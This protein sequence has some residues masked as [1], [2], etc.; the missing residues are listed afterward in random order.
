MRANAA[1]EP[2]RAGEDD[3][4]RNQE[5]RDTHVIQARD[6]AGRVI[7]VHRAQHLVA[8]QRGFDRDFRGF[9]ITDFADHDDVRVLAQ[10]R[11]KRVGES[12]AD[13]FLHRH[14]V[15]AGN[16]EFH[17][18]FNRDDVVDRDCSVRSARNKA[19]WSCRNLSGR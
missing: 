19:S 9:G 16:L 13:L 7:T 17:R 15:D 5:R 11:A 1:H 3:R 8:R 2:L 10:N 4:G 18:V 14:L 6:G 12:E